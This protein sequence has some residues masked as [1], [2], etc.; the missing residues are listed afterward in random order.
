MK[1]LI[2]GT[3]G[4]IGKTLSVEFIQQN[5][6]ISIAVRQKTNLFLDAVK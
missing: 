4:F 5:F 2:T 3:T 1:I 6:S